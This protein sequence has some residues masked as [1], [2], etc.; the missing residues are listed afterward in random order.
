MGFGVWKKER[1]IKTA[2]IGGVGSGIPGMVQT[3][4]F[5]CTCRWTPLLI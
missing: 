4:S 2:D 1:G 3:S 5:F